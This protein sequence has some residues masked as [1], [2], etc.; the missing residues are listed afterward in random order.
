M[1]QPHPSGM[2]VAQGAALTIGAVLG[3]GV[4]SLPAMAAGIAG[5]A[6]LVAWVVLVVLSAPLALTFARLGS[7]FP[8]A[9]GVSTYA[10]LAFGR[11]T[12]T[13]VGWLFYLVVAV[14]A[15]PAGAFAGGYVADL[16]GG[17]RT[18]TMWVAGVLLGA[19]AV[20]NWF[21]VRVSGRV[22]LGLATLLA[23]LLT[24]AT[25]AALP[26]AD[27]GHLTPFAPN[28]WGAV[29]P[30]AAVVVWG[31]AGWEAVTS[32]TADYRDPAR[33]V[34]RAAVVAVVVVGVLYLGVVAT[35]ILVLGPRTGSSQA[36]LADLLGV[37]FGAPGRVVTTV[38][39]VLLTVGAMNAYFAGA[40]RLGAA[41]GRDGSLPAWFAQGGQA[42]QV[43]RRALAVTTVLSLTSLVATA[44]L[45]LDLSA[46]VL[47]ATGAFTVIYVIGTAAAIRL[48]PRG[49]WAWRG[50]VLSFVSVTLL[51]AVN[52]AHALWTVGV[53][54]AA[55]GYETLVSRR[56]TRTSRRSPSSSR[57]SA[58][59]PYPTTTP[60]TAE[61]DA[62]SVR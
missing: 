26:Y 7:R 56:R 9:G 14:G 40:A 58:T 8:D 52:G 53:A 55:V 2:S 42:G 10:R 44:L 24:V 38:V 20:L 59:A 57:S 6:S 23:L 45:H 62:C 34:P 46:S 11:R 22:Q 39:A 16:V 36:P 41:L 17:S 61:V 25:V 15:P 13:A 31:F 21:G 33:D 30:A 5:P 19:V 18:T 27:L 49:T 1:P 48:L 29:A 3:T 51:L 50:A 54:A 12:A 60:S 28:G 4:I 32:L 47:L 43:P 37:A 35:S